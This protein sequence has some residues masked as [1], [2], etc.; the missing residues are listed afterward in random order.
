MSPDGQ[1]GG[2]EVGCGGQEARPAVP[3]TGAGL[4]SEGRESTPGLQLEAGHTWIRRPCLLGMQRRV[5]D[6]FCTDSQHA[7]SHHG[8]PSITPPFHIPIRPPSACPDTMG[9]AGHCLAPVV[10]LISLNCSKKR[11][12]A[13]R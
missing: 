13:P 11:D 2:G 5:P 3:A 9:P 8:R 1:G 6:G 10:S 7:H 4:T 12:V